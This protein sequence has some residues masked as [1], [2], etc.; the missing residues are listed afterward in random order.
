MEDFKIGDYVYGYLV[1]PHEFPPIPH[2]TV[3]G[4]VIR[5]NEKG[6]PVVSVPIGGGGYKT[7]NNFYGIQYAEEYTLRKEYAFRSAL[8]RQD[9]LISK[10]NDSFSRMKLGV[11]Y[12]EPHTPKECWNI[13][14]FYFQ[15]ML[16]FYF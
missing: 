7:C 9:Y 3:E 16:A 4:E 10:I 6:C 13:I 2:T 14:V 8:E 5:I 11:V 12:R 15:K 1:F